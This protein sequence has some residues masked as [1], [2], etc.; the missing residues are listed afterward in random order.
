MG[1]R[2]STS[3]LNSITT[4]AK[5][6]YDRQA[7]N[8]GIVHLGM[9]G[10]HRAHQAVYTDK[11]LADG[12]RNWGITGVSLRSS[13]VR[14]L[15]TP[16]D[17]L[18]S[19]NTLGE[20]APPPQIIGSVLNT[21][22]IRDHKQLTAALDLIA[23][24]STQVISLTIT[25]KG[26]CANQ[27]GDLD[28]RHPDIALD[29]AN[30]QRPQSAPGLL[31]VGLQQR[32]RAGGG[33][34]SILSCDNL[35]GNGRV[36][37]QVVQSM[38]A[39][40]NPEFATWIA[41]HVSFPSTMVDR[42]VPQT[43][44][45]DIDAFESVSGYRD[46]ALVSGEAFTQWVIEDDFRGQR[47]A[48]DIA[49]AQFV[50]KVAPFEQ[51]KLRLLNATHSAL[52][53][54]GLLTDHAYVHQALAYPAIGDFVTR[55]L[56]DEITPEVDC[57]QGMDITDYKARLL[58]RFANAAVPYK[59][60]QV[61]GDGSQKLPQRIFPTLSARLNKQQPVALLCTVVGAW[62]QCLAGRSDTGVP[63][64]VSDPAA[65]EIAQLAAKH[66]NAP[67]LIQAIAQQSNYFGELANSSEFLTQLGDALGK[68]RSE[69]TAASIRPL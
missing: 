69:G 14:D 31:A 20:G 52:A 38:A 55:L 64:S 49:G 50:D 6:T 46:D 12:Q 21:L 57:P 26:Y 32:M 53:Y 51:A 54:L 2:L 5:P 24:P 23:Q 3:T 13:S 41:D 18:Y 65:P 37:Q 45:G 1:I 48:W 34:I 44:V 63:I 58:K 29:L 35:A 19:A 15:L 68:L 9:G 27:N 61:A 4:A 67:E 39:Q 22:A 25:E 11:L 33:S 30:W 8:T 40:L 59:T 60:L 7:I 43:S 56:N 36:T 66:A 16:Q 10:F 42:I 62:I 47:P 17:F 28:I